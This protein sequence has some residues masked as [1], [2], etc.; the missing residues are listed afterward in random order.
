[1]L[2]LVGCAQKQVSEYT[3][4]MENQTFVINTENKTITND[5]DIYKYRVDETTYH[6]T[7]PDNSKY[8]WTQQD[9][10]GYGGY[11]DDH[12]ENKYIPG[13]VL[14]DVISIKHNSRN[15]Q[16]DFLLI[17]VLLFFGM[18]NAMSPYSS[19]YLSYGW[20]YKDVEP[21]DFALGFGRISG[22][23]MVIVG[24]ILFFV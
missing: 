16:K 17:G 23:I 8:E 24:L 15:V 18:W 20:R 9:T 21:S 4:T 2:F 14:V 6:I 11:S 5:G 1:M 12:N 7:Y 10:I 13:E 3:I 19:W 22:I